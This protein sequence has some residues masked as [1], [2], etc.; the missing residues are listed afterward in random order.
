MAIYVFIR[1]TATPTLEINQNLLNYLKL[2]TFDFQS[3]F[4]S[5]IND[6][7]NKK[8]HLISAQK[9]SDFVP[10]LTWLLRPFLVY[11]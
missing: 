9:T 3:R 8:D 7:C 5:D 1:S 4:R 11:F 10:F 6:K 2:M